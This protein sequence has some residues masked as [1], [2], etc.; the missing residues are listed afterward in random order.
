MMDYEE[1]KKDN[2]ETCSKLRGQDR[3]DFMEEVFEDYQFA[4]QY[5]ITPKVKRYYRE[6]L[7]ELIK[8]FGN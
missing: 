6:L 8:N 1:L 2:I 4:T 7:A 3:I 5:Y